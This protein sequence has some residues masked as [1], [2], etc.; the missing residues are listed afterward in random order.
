MRDPQRDQFTGR[1]R[2]IEKI[3]RRGGAFEASGTLGQSYYVR[4][5][6]RGRRRPALRSALLVLFIL[7]GFKALLLASMGEPAYVEKLVGLKSGGTVDRVGAYVMAIDPFTETI[8]GALSP[9]FK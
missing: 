4:E 8:A 6:E 1:L 7:V 3:H 2:R 9:Y 5:Y